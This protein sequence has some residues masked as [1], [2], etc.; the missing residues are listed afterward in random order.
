MAQTATKLSWH[1]NENYRAKHYKQRW[2]AILGFYIKTKSK[3]RPIMFKTIEYHGF[4]THGEAWE[5]TQN[6]LPAE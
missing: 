4:E 1:I 2:L 6:H 5:Y 3:T